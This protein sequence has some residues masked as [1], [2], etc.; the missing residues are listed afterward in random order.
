MKFS[1]AMAMNEVADGRFTAGFD[2]SW[3]V[4]NGPNG[5]IIAA[6]CLRAAQQC[7]GVERT[8]RT[9]STH[10]LSAPGEGN[11]DIEVT[12]EK[13]GRIAGFASVRMTQ[14][15]RPIAI[16]L[17]AVGDL[18]DS[19]Q[20]WEQR[21]FPALPSIDETWTMA[22]ESP[23]VPLRQRWEQLWGVGVPGHS[24]TSTI[25]GAYEVGGW[26]RLSEPEPYDAA[27]LTAM[28]DSWVPAIMIHTDLPVHTPTVELTVQFRVD[29]GKLELADDSFCASVFRQLSGRNGFLDES[30]EIWSR[31]GDL[32][33]LSRQIGVILP[34]EADTIGEWK[35]T[36][37]Q[38]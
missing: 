21:D 15:A 27:I 7:L 11:V 16:A 8:V 29:P 4:V 14:R 9:I 31:E 19:L 37:T 24:E 33:A 12:V 2:R 22:S 28:A 32:L 18:E 36:R 25:A 38:D 35:F 6:L 13:L 3:W 5:G 30:G 34:R 26:C 17:V 20:S 23:L 10:F 1:K